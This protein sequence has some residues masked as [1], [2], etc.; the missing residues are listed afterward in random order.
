VDAPA[1]VVL[2]GRP[3]RRLHVGRHRLSAGARRLPASGGGTA[4]ARGSGSPS[5]SAVRRT[6]EARRWPKDLAPDVSEKTTIIEQQAWGP[7]YQAII[8]G[9]KSP[10]PGVADLK[11]QATQILAQP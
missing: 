7:V 9:Q 6:A 4:S 1:P 8:A 11:Q 5:G 3:G 2:A 10:K